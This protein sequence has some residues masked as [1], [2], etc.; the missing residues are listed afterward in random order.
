MRYFEEYRCGCVS[1]IVRSKKALLG[2]C[3]THGDDSRCVF[4]VFNDKGQ[5][6]GTALHTMR[7][8]REAALSTGRK[9]PGLL[10][11]RRKN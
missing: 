4:P 3:G 6:D 8:D 2:Y 1:E 5:F 7:T 10:R 11:D 9:L